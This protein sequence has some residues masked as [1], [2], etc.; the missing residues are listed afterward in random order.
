[1]PS[2]PARLLCTGD[3]HVGRFP[4]YVPPDDRSL[5]VEATWSR[6]VDRAIQEAVDAV[7]LTGDVADEDNKVFEAFDPLL[8]GV[9][10][11]YAAG[12]RTFAVAGNHDFDALH[13]LRDLVAARLGS[14]AFTLLGPRGSWT[15]AVIERDGK[16][17]L[18]LMGWS[19]P[20]RYVD[21]SPLDTM[22]SVGPEV[23][24]IGVLHA[25]L[26]V[27]ESR[28]AP[29]RR[30][31]LA[32]SPVAAWLL[33]HIHRPSFQNGVLYPG[34]LQPLDPGERGAHGPWLVT[35]EGASVDAR[36]LPLATVRYDEVDVDLGGVEDAA[37]AERAVIAGVENHLK[38]VGAAQ[39]DAIQHVLDVRFVRPHA[40][41]R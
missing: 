23:P 6:T 31:D 33:G 19:F 38:A 24:T 26:D 29:V 5:S 2:T 28:Y 4:S 22:P 7:V 25:D 18:R 20:D 16:P 41:P 21:V 11:L 17:L 12:I 35:I 36:Q 40:P 3:L 8:R 39:P 13:R 27:A 10:R 34:S 32:A 9:E 14:E 30:A 1:M 15:S 37:A